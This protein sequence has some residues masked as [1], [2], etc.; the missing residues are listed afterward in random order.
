[1]R[2][3]DQFPTLLKACG[4][5]ES[6]SIALSSHVNGGLPF[7]GRPFGTSV[8]RAVSGVPQ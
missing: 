2:S 6:A 4:G 1:M 8:V 5:S 3:S 7:F